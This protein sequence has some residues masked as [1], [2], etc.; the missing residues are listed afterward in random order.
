MATCQTSCCISILKATV[1]LKPYRD[2]CVTPL[3]ADQPYEGIGNMNQFDMTLNITEIRQ[4]NNQNAGGG[5]TCT[6]DK[7]NDVSIS[8]VFTCL[9][10][11]NIARQLKAEPGT[12]A[13]GAN[14]AYS[15]TL[16]AFDEIFPLPDI[17]IAGSVA[18][19]GLVAGT[20]FKLTDNGTGVQLL[21]SPTVQALTIG[22]ATL[23]ITYSRAAQTDFQ[24]GNSPN[25]YWSVWIDG[26]NSADGKPYS[27]VLNKVKI[28]PG[29]ALSFIGQSDTEAQTF[30]ISG[31]AEDDPCSEFGTLVAGQPKSRI[32]A[33]RTTMNA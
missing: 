1:M 23:A 15:K 29:G 10:K 27:G 3:P 20:D 33:F 13:A 22:T 24:I 14:I 5:F 16:R 28:T 31:T 25:K 4:R 6:I 21:N 19:T 7:I 30:Q 2:C 32:G 9:S 18:I 8:G 26:I 11:S 12:V 17:P